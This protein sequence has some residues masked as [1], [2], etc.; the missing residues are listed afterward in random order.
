M[1]IDKLDFDDSLTANKFIK[2]DESEVI[3]EIISNKKIIKAIR[4]EKDNMKIIDIPLP[5]ITHD[6]VIKSYDKVI[7]YLK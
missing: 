4:S 3:Y 6:K 2:G 1:L 7:I 5:K